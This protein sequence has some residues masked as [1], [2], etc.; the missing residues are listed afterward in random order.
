MLMASHCRHC[1]FIRSR[2]LIYWQK[3]TLCEICFSCPLA[4][5]LSLPVSHLIGKLSSKECDEA[6]K[7]TRLRHCH[8]RP[9]RT[10]TVDDDCND[11]CHPDKSNFSEK[12]SSFPIFKSR[13]EPNDDGPVCHT[14]ATKQWTKKKTRKTRCK[15]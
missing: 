3:S 9:M 13:F 4:L 6:D 11:K 10:S 15:C 8:T 12:G 2:R 1:N 14:Y 5:S 7:C